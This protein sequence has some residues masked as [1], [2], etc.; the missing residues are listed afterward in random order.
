MGHLKRGGQQRALADGDI[1]LI[2]FLEPA[3][4]VAV[5]PVLIRYQ[6]RFLRQGDARGQSVAETP[7]GVTQ[8]DGADGGFHG[9]RHLVHVGVIRDGERRHAVD[10]A[11]KTAVVH[12]A[13]AADEHAA[14]TEDVG[15]LFH[16]PVAQGSRHGD[17][18]EGG[19]RG[20]H[21]RKGTADK[22]CGRV[23]AQLFVVLLG[24]FRDKNIR[25]EV[26]G[27]R[28]HQDFA[29]VHIDEDEGPAMVRVLVE[30]LF[31]C[32][33]PFQVQGCYHRAAGLGLN[34]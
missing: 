33:L 16:D 8:A 5:H 11:L 12:K 28:Q 1:R 14:G 7:R 2:A 20:I 18:L 30:G 15:G 19:G 27:G 34:L 17:G 21:A 29:G 10:A 31:C 32:L 3:T 9:G 25:V 24:D 22:R 23:F 13:V 6:P 4:V 26:R